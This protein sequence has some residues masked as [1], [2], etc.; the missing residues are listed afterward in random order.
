MEN[1]TKAL[2]IA[3]GILLT[4]MILSIILVAYNQ[5]SDYY[6]SESEMV[7]AQ[8]LEEFNK[9]FE[10]YNRKNIR[11]NDIIS[12]MNKIVDYNERQ[13]YQAGSG[14]KR[15]EATLE[16]GND[17]ILNQFKYSTHTAWDLNPF[18]K[19]KITN[20]NSSDQELVNITETIKYLST[21]FQSEGVTLTDLEFQV[22]ASNASNI[23]L[24]NSEEIGLDEYSKS[25]RE[26]R[27]KILKKIGINIELDSNLI[28][29]DQSANSRMNKVKSITNRYYQYM[30]FKRACFDCTGVKYDTETGRVYEM[31][32]KLITEVENGQVLVKFD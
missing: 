12:L 32:F 22:L 3:A 4:I 8:Q 1:A 11:G 14:Y 20:K 7:V 25:K 10:N 28:P 29:K 9:Q 31:T 27:D 26:K 17:N 19:Q 13:V 6:K 15:I 24:S 5:I 23:L 30:Q 18:L 2:L 21:Y 16:M